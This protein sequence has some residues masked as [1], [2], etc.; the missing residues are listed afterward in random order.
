MKDDE[1]SR[2][3]AAVDRFLANDFIA[4]LPKW[5]RKHEN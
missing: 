3:T 4:S 1:L 2:E 5:W